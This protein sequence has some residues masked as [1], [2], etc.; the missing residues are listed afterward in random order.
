MNK[1]AENSIY[2]TGDILP[3]YLAF[4]KIKTPDKKEYKASKD[5][6]PYKIKRSGIYQIEHHG[7]IYKIYANPP[8]LELKHMNVDINTLDSFY[9]NYFIVYNITL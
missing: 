6:G 3:S 4:T 1:K 8:A 9:S 2:Q 5:S 7:S